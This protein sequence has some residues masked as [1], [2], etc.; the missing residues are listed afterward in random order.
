MGDTLA[1]IL[2]RM[3][4]KASVGVRGSVRVSEDKKRKPTDFSQGGYSSV[5]THVVTR[6]Q[7][8]QISSMMENEP[9]AELEFS[10][11]R[12]DRARFIPGVTLASFLN[13]KEQLLDFK[14]PNSNLDVFESETEVGLPGEGYSEYRQ[15]KDLKTGFVG[16]QIKERVTKPLDNHTWGWRCK[17]SKETNV[18][19]LPKKATIQATRKKQRISVTDLNKKSPIHGVKFDLTTVVFSYEGRTTT[20]YEVEIERNDPQVSPG[21]IVNIVNLVVKWLQFGEGSKP[22]VELM[23]ERERASVINSHNSLLKTKRR[24]LALGYWN[25]PINL[26][27]IQLLKIREFLQTIKLDGERRFIYFTEEAIYAILPPDYIRRVNKNPIPEL[28]G[29]LIDGEI[30]SNT[31]YAFDIL[32]AQKRD[33]RKETTTKRLAFLKKYRQGFAKSLTKIQYREKRY[34]S[35]SRGDGDPYDATTELVKQIVESDVEVDGIIYQPI[36]AEYRNNKTYKWKPASLMTIDFLLKS[37]ESNE[38]TEGTATESL[39]AQEFWLMVNDKGTNVVFQGDEERPFSGKI[40]VPDGTLVSEG[41]KTSVN[42]KIVEC[43]YYSANNTF[44]PY[45]IRSDRERPNA[46]HVSQNVWRDIINPVTLETIRGDSLAV[47]RKYHNLIKMKLY[48]NYMKG[49][50]TTLE[51][52]TGRGGDLLKMEKVGIKKVFSVDPD[53]K[54]MNEMLRRAPNFKVEVVPIVGGGEDTDKIKKVIGKHK[55][56]AMAAFF[57]LTFFAKDKAIYSGLL[58]TI[59]TFLQKG[60]YFVGTVMDGER[61]FDFIKNKT[62]VPTYEKDVEPPFSIRALSPLSKRKKFGNKIQISISDSTAIFSEQTEY[63][64]MFGKFVVD[65]EKIGIHLIFTEYLTKNSEVLPKASRLFT[66]LYRSFV[67]QRK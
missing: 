9:D 62:Q 57:S 59:D 48:E 28:N 8:E 41:T 42:G 20:I 49:A 55:I 16:Y 12:F 14:D 27:T 65:L 7:V 54:N 61:A 32:F 26:P 38:S 3:D 67:F 11:G 31:F 63:L 25:K 39:S 18:R 64:F 5:S 13:V 40:T 2:S 51:I 23:S 22:E 33:L 4:A 1:N 29:T 15:I 36:D 52:G 10:F 19:E 37:T 53:E 50:K 43:K 35:S 21:K 47:L 17:L 6:Q 60:D 46:L 24:G 30:V 34:Y 44:V 56:N 66:S 58:K 45:R